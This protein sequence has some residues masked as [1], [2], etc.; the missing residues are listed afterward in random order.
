MFEGFKVVVL[1]RVVLWENNKVV[2]WCGGGVVTCKV[3]NDLW[4]V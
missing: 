3:I 2:W 4:I 1:C